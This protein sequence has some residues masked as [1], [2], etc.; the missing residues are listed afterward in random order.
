MQQ[1][2]SEELV[3]ETSK[4]AIIVTKHAYERANERLNWNAKVL[5]KMA[6]K[7]YLEGI[8]HKNTKGTLNRYITKIWFA[9]KQ[10][11]NIRIYG[12][13]IFFFCD[14]RLVTLYQ[15][16]NDLRKHVKYCK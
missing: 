5:D 3:K 16:S 15:L 11:N 9:Y 7:A 12:E 14:N 2:K 10:C 1:I 13:N 4:Q 8:N 6:E